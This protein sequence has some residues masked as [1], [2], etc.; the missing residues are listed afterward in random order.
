MVICRLL[1]LKHISSFDIVVGSWLLVS[2]FPAVLTIVFSQISIEIDV[3]LDSNFIK[4]ARNPLALALSHEVN[5]FRGVI[6]PTSV[7]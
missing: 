2:S 3:S 1:A 4:E 6:Q 5:G 7:D